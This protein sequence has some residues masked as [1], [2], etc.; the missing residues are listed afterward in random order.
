MAESELNFLDSSR[1]LEAT[2]G[3]N[4]RLF[5]PLGAVSRRLDRELDA[6]DRSCRESVMLD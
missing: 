1:G 2:L 6:K 5:R 4:S 3:K